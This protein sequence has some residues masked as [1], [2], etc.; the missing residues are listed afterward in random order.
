MLI[1]FS[2][3]CLAIFL[4]KD[5]TPEIDFSE[6]RIKLTPDDPEYVRSVNEGII[7]SC[8]GIDN[9]YTKWLRPDGFEVSSKGRVHVETIKGQSRLIF[10]SITKDD[11]GKWTCKLDN[12]EGD[13][14]S[15]VMNVYGEIIL[16]NLEHVFY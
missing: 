4:C 14:K 12:D 15:F 1:I 2:S 13:G 9:N 16:K 7:V 5:A 10:D 6:N 8:E 11:M 3:Y